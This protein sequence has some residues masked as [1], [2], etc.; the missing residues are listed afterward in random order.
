ML[1]AGELITVNRTAQRI[2]AERVIIFRC[3]PDFYIEKTTP[4]FT[5]GC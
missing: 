5:T 2:D 4:Y 3:L 1:V